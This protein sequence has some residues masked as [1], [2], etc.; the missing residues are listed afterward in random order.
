MKADVR[1]NVK[2]GGKGLVGDRGLGVFGSCVE[3]GILRR[4]VSA[5]FSTSIGED[6]QMQYRE[7]RRISQCCVTEAWRA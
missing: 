3:Y 4:A 6:F 2:S 5:V 7:K 1:G